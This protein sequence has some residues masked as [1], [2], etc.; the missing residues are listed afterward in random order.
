MKY[1]ELA[2]DTQYNGD[3]VFFAFSVKQFAEGE[4]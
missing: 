2:Y 3:G 4:E 1:K